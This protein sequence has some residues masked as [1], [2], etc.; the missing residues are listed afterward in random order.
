MLHLTLL[1]LLYMPQKKPLEIR[2]NLIFFAETKYWLNKGLCGKV[3]QGK[4]IK[5]YLKRLR[6]KN[7]STDKDKQDI[8]KGAQLLNACVIE[9]TLG[10]VCKWPL[11]KLF[12]NN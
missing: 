4:P 2:P 1:Y 8:W 12:H 3:W 10:F 6:K 5:K 11:D 7:Y 9:Q